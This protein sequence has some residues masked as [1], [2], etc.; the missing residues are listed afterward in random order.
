MPRW[1]VYSRADCSLCD[2]L[3]TELA[4]L[5][6]PAAA[7][8]VIVLD[9]DNDVVT[10]EKYAQRVPVLLAD[11]DFVCAYRLDRQRVEALLND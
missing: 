11:G 4:D 1:I 8:E 3:L 2:Q 7:G 9:V 10:R 6:G 5:L